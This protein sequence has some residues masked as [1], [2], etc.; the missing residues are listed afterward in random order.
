MPSD[1][2]AG[3]S[4][5]SVDQSCN[6]K[7]ESPSAYAITLQMRRQPPEK[8]FAKRRESLHKES[9]VLVCVDGMAEKALLA[10]VGRAVAEAHRMVL[11]HA[12]AHQM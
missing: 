5:G 8:P 4:K 2:E 7:A 11:I 10:A 9:V 1:G 6:R 12:E 3:H